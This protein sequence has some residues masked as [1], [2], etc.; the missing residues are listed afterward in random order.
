MHLNLHEVSVLRILVCVFSG[1]S[2]VGSFLIIWSYYAFPKLRSP[3]SKLVLCLSIAISGSDLTALIFINGGDCELYG[4]F[5]SYFI[6]ASMAWSVACARTLNRYVVYRHSLHASLTRLT[7]LKVQNIQSKRSIVIHVI[8]WG[9]SFVF[10]II[11]NILSTTGDS[12]IT[13]NWCWFQ[14]LKEKEKEDGSNGTVA[15]AESMNVTLTI[16]F[17]IPIVIATI[18]NY[19]CLSGKYCKSMINFW[20]RNNEYENYT[21]NEGSSPLEKELMKLSNF[22][23]DF[24]IISVMISSWLCI[25][26]IINISINTNSRVWVFVILI[27]LLRLH[28]ALNFIIYFFK[29]EQRRLKWYH[30]LF[31]PE[32]D[33]E[34]NQSNQINNEDEEHS[35]LNS[36]LL[37]NDV[38]EEN[39]ILVQQKMQ[40]NDQYEPPEY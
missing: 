17:Y 34:N 33:Y 12:S 3:S 27:T 1:L 39:P 38:I 40:Y 6:L 9:V 28:G 11:I 8:A 31:F 36:N 23:S 2:L 14:E 19:W 16:L 30:T 21:G 18:Y 10:A 5:Q 29:D 35:N 24:V 13:S 26:V 37:L 15:V 4:L 7:S 32:N 20:Y 25:S 22:L